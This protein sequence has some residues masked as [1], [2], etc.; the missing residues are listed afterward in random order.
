MNDIKMLSEIKKRKGYTYAEMAAAM[1]VTLVT[2][3]RWLKG[4]NDPS[5][6][7]KARINHY[8]H[9]ESTREG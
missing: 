8:I 3:F 2:V 7:A 1:G 5:P 6:M 9:S 4:K